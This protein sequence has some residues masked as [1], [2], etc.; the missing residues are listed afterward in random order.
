[1]AKY[2]VGLVLSG[3]AAR[4]F[5]HLGVLK[6]LEEKGLKPGIISGVSAGAIAGAFYADGYTPEEILEIYIG[7][8]LFD[9]VQITLPRTGL[10]KLTGMKNVLKKHL[11]AK[12]FDDL[13][14]PLVVT[15]T[16][17][18]QG[19]PVYLREGD[20]SEAILA[21]SAVPV[22]F[23]VIMIGNVEY[24]DGGI[25]NNLPLAPIADDCSTLVGV[26]VNHSGYQENVKGIANIAERA[27]HLA[28]AADVERKKSHFDLFIEPK[29]I[30]NYGFFN[31]KNGQELFRVGYDTAMEVLGKGQSRAGM[32]M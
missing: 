28:V 29:D 17:L 7:H 24:I 16:D 9:F 31:L 13:N 1:M 8:N 10:F 30:A 19:K 23:E 2:D 5:A 27:F 12:R 21:S 4:G 3:G 6:A 22:L 26:Y 32:R 25:T 14:I 18:N 20:L 15:A 11:R